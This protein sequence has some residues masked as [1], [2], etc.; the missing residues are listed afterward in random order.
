MQV[1]FTGASGKTATTR[2]ANKEKPPHTGDGF[3]VR[4]N[5]IAFHFFFDT[6]TSS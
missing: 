5:L 3:F 1:C 2:L 4:E 6:A